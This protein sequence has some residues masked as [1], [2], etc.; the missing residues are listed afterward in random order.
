M[1]RRLNLGAATAMI[2][3]VGC[4]LSHDVAGTDDAGG[5]DAATDS[6]PPDG[7]NTFADS[8]V[9]IPGCSSAA[10]EILIMGFDLTGPL[11]NRFNPTTLTFESPLAIS[12]CP[13]GT[14]FAGR[15]PW[16]AVLDRNAT[17]WSHY[18]E[19][20]NNTQQFIYNRVFTIDTSSGVCT[21]TG[22][23][24]VHPSGKNFEYG[25]AFLP[26]PNDLQK[27]ILYASA[28]NEPAFGNPE[29]DTV[30]TT[31]M[32]PTLVGPL[33][34]TAHSF[35]TS[36]GDGRLFTL[37]KGS[38]GWGVRELDPKTG[39]SLADHPVTGLSTSQ[40]PFI[41]WGGTLYAFFNKTYDPQS[42]VTDVYRINLQTW[43]AGV[44]ASGNFFVSAAAV[45]TCAP[46][47]PPK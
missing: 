12:G 30:N 35:L 8:G 37:Y 44:V 18:L 40:G 11:V 36:T 32:T 31:S 10:G 23:G 26:D 45:S 13:A 16:A 29:L 24:L 6:A 41:F 25:L 19:W 3:L 38:T 46:L 21:D 5:A 39:A 43:T 7:Q 22:H 28:F 34:A 4:A 17:I 27:D 33:T 20:D 15:N 1:T 47:V 42:L 2:A 9:S 14:G